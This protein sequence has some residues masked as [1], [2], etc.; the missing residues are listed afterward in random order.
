M[1]RLGWPAA[2]AAFVAVLVVCCALVWPLPLHLSTWHATSAFG[3]SHVWVWDHQWR[4]LIGGRPLDPS[5]YAGFPVARAFRAIGQGP[6]VAVTALRP[7]LGPLGAANVVQLLSLPLSAVAAAVLVRRWTGAAPLAAAALGAAYALCPN[8]LATFA[9][10]E[11]SNTQAWIVPAFLLALD[12]ASRRWVGLLAVG[13]VGVLAAF[14]SPYLALSLPL[15]FAGW[16]VSHGWQQ[17][18]SAW[19]ALARILAVLAVL[20]ASL[21]PANSYYQPDE[22]GGGESIFQPARGAQLARGATGRQAAVPV[23]SP[24]A[25]PDQLLMGARTQPRGPT[26]VGHSVYLGLALVLAAIGVGVVRRR[27][28]PVGVALAAGGVLLAMG[29]L[30]ALNGSYTALGA[31]VAMPVALLERAHYPTAFGGM[32]FRYITLAV[33]G[34]LLVVGKGLA[35][36]RYAVPAAG[37]LLVIQVV[38][39]LRETGPWWPRPV[40]EVAGL[41]VLASLEGQ[42]GAVVEL[43]LQGPTD[44]ILGQEALL[45]AVFHGRPVSALPRDMMGVRSPLPSA[46]RRL[47]RDPEGGVAAL[48]ALGVRFLLLPAELADYT[49]PSMPELR[50]ALG[51]PLHDGALI[52]WDLGPTEARCVGGTTPPSQ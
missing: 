9:T 45:R 36:W 8:L 28:H 13:T 27:V 51:A 33:L 10:L 24:V 23:P 22:A 32:Y 39:G 40:A 35:G 14:T 48:S 16:A 15:L 3:D 12:F 19:A 31:W 43:P 25:Q 50:A 44:A 18:R 29:P 21:F 1:P 4:A 26:S 47:S 42:D 30:L 46:V 34:L 2:L 20:F 5:C 6:A 41:Q 11:I 37:A 17:R 38:D 52:V 7:L 49:E